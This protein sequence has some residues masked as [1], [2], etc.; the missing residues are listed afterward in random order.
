[1][2]CQAV[3][4]SQSSGPDGYAIAAGIIFLPVVLPIAIIGA[5]GYGMYAGVRLAAKQIAIATNKVQAARLQLIA[6]TTLQLQKA[7]DTKTKL[8]E[9]KAANLKNQEE[10]NT[11]LA[12]ATATVAMEN[13]IKAQDVTN[14]PAGPKELLTKAVSLIDSEKKKAEKEM[15]TY[16]VSLK[17]VTKELAEAD[18]RLPKLET[19]I[20]ALSETLKATQK[21]Y[22]DAGALCKITEK[23]I[24]WQSAFKSRSEETE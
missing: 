4:K 19:R 23:L 5:L 6:E 16:Q 8:E 20:A 7:T 17:I 18:I 24:T 13:P 15:S 11:L 21:L 3:H 9:R 12:N 14:Q 10:I 22:Q 1:M 2:S